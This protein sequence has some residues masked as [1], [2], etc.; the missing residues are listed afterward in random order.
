M[1]R[2]KL[3]PLTVWLCR[4]LYRRTGVSIAELR[5]TLAPGVSHEAL[6]C[7]IYGSSWSEV[8]HPPRVQRRV[9]DRDTG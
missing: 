9:L 8:P 2:A 4:L 3:D 1:T 7:A 5:R 6:R